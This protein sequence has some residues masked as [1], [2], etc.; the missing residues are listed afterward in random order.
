MDRIYEYRWQQFA[1]RLVDGRSLKRLQRRRLFFVG[2]MLA[3]AGLSVAESVD[4]CFSPER[5]DIAAKEWSRRPWV[6]IRKMETERDQLLEKISVLPQHDPIFLS[7]HLGHHSFFEKPDSNGAFPLHQ[8]DIKLSRPNGLNSI[9][10]APAFNPK[11]AGAYAFPKRFKIEVLDTKTGEFEVVVNWMEEDFPNP[12]PY[13]VFFADINRS[14]TQV[15][16]TVAQTAQETAVAY[17]AL[18]EVYLFRQRSDGRIG[19]NMAPWI[20]TEIEAS[21]SI[22]MLSLWNTRYLNDG[23][24]G[25]GYPLSDIIVAAPDLSMSSGSESTL[26]GPVQ[27]TLD[28]GL[29]QPLGPIDFW[30]AEA[31]HQLSLPA[32][33]F[34]EKILIELSNDPEFTKVVAFKG[35][36]SNRDLLAT[37]PFTVRSGG[38]HRA[39]YIRITLNGFHEYR[40]DRILGLGEISVSNDE[41]VWSLDCQITAKGIPEEYLDQLPRL[42]DGC[43]RKRRILSQGEWIKGL[44]QRRPLDRRLAVVAKELELTRVSWRTT[45]LRI[46]IWGGITVFAGLIIGIV[47]QRLQRRRILDRLKWRI[48]RDLHD[49]VGSN[50]GSISL[51]AEQLKHS[52]LDEEAKEELDDLSLLASEACASLREVVWVIDESTLRLP[53]LIQKLV[54]RAERV[55]G[56]MELFFEISEGCPDC[57][58]SLTFKRHLIMFFKEVVHNCARHSQATQVWVAFS[59]DDHCLQVSIRDNGC[60]FNPAEVAG[61]LGLESMEERAEEMGGALELNSRPGEGTTVVLTVPLTALLSKTDHLYKTSN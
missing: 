25:F 48:T 51:T 61:G 46:S 31:P 17:C 47:L 5:S 35:K 3:L 2:W 18:G 36:S 40:G 43:I 53:G 15:R 23:L 60:G 13:P 28:L 20:D 22:T 33:G 49:D 24:T 16:I 58:V 55:L 39:R 26:S 21:D 9:A 41:R 56:G 10:L 42:V 59:A 44:A 52:V 32:F 7:E 38:G 30:P 54:E 57:V 4:P 11:E 8:L 29:V 14:V 45:Q 12:G 34:P 27:I 6:R 1:L 19:V 37:K 50:L